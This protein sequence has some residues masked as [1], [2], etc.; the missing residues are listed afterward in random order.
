MPT[1]AYDPACVRDPAIKLLLSHAAT[2]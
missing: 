1:D 2:L